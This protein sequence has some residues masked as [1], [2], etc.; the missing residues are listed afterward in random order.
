MKLDEKIL[1]LVLIS[2]FFGLILAH[3][4][5]K[6]AVIT[7]DGPRLRTLA[8]ASIFGFSVGIIGISGVPPLI[9]F[10]ILRALNKDTGPV[11]I[12]WCFMAAIVGLWMIGGA[13]V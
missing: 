9:I 11:I 1:I 13:T 6:I 10:V 7:P 8:P 5:G 2:V 4:E 12:I 3:L